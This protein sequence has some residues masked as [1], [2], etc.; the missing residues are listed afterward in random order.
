MLQRYKSSFPKS[1]QKSYR[2]STSHQIEPV[3]TTDPEIV[4]AVLKKDGMA[5]WQVEEPLRSDK[6][7]VLE[8]VKS[9]PRAF[10]YVRA[11]LRSDPHIKWWAKSTPLQRAL[12]KVRSV[13]WTIGLLRGWMEWVAKRQE[14]ARIEAASRGHVE[15]T[16]VEEAATLPPSSLSQS[17]VLVLR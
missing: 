10:G 16:W 1:Y 14:E 12:R 6:R 9:N 8:A 11:P 17:K 3:F 4:I 15:E 2:S 13:V 5:L 7:I